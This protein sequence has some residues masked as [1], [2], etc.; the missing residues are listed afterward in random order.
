[1]D[2]TITIGIAVIVLSL[3]HGISLWV[4]WQLTCRA[5]WVDENDRY[6]ITEKGDAL[7]KDRPCGPSP[8]TLQPGK[9]ASP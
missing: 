9:P 5:P 6:I 1:M 3:S 7:L 4:L 8:D 2:P